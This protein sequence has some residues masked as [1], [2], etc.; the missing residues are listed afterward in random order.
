MRGFGKP[1][2]IDIPVPIPV[3]QQLCDYLD[4]EPQKREISEVASR[5]QS[6]PRSIRGP[7]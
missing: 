1:F 4:S 5:A 2:V 6:M 3:F 7:C